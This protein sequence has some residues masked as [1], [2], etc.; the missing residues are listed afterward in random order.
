MLR[1]LFGLTKDDRRAP[2]DRSRLTAKNDGIFEEIQSVIN[3]SGR[4]AISYITQIAESLDVDGFVSYVGGP[5]LAGTSVQEGTL[6]QP[7]VDGAGRNRARTLLFRPADML[8]AMKA[9]VDSEPIQQ[10]IYPLAA[11]LSAPH[12]ETK[13]L[14][15]G[16]EVGNDL[17]IPDFSISREHAEIRLFARKFSVADLGSSNGT[18]V[19]GVSLDRS[20]LVLAYGDVIGFARYEFAFLHPATLYSI[21]LRRKKGG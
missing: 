1:Y 10:A 18:K 7:P 6:V 5:V 21:L 9:K 2:T 17:V 3:S 15:V 16:R 20:P 8:A 4:V 11:R 12:S 14:T 19:N 13:T